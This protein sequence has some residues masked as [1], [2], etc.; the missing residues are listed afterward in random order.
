MNEGKVKISTGSL[1]YNR[2]DSIMVELLHFAGNDSQV[3]KG[4]L[5]IVPA[6]AKPG[7]P[8]Q[9]KNNDREEADF[10]LDFLPDL[11]GVSL[12]GRVVGSE[13]N[14]T[15]A[16]SRIHFTLL[17]EQPGYAVA[18]ADAHGRFSLSLP[19]REGRLELFVQ[20]EQAGAGVMEVRID[21]DFDSRVLPLDF[22]SFSLNQKEKQ[23]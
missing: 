5:S 19:S 10:Q 21:Q 18:H 7:L 14:Q 17:G 22:P 4:C 11:F 23:E 2:G 3:V 15:L 8:L 9:V 12:S 13:E 20:P 16:G 6:S 1:S